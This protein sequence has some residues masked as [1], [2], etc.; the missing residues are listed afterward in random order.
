MKPASGRGHYWR[1]FWRGLYSFTPM[2]PSWLF[3]PTQLYCKRHILFLHT[4][5]QIVSAS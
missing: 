1:T 5:Y 3:S 4:G 2:L